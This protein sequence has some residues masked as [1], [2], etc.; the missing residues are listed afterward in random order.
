M[1]IPGAASPLFLA[2]AAAAAAPAGHQI[3]RS[4]RFNQSD[5]ANLSKTFSSG[6]RKTWTLSWWM[7]L[8]KLGSNRGLFG[9][10]GSSSGSPQFFTRINT[11]D[12]LYV[13]EY[14]TSGGYQFIKETDMRLRD[15][16]AWYH[17]V[18]QFD[19]TQS[20]AEDGFKIYI[21]G[22]RVT[23]WATNNLTNYAQNY[24]GAWNSNANTG[25]HKIGLCDQYFDGYLAEIHFV[26]GTQLAATD[27]G[28]ED[29]NGVW[30]PIDCKDNLTYGTNGFYL[31]F[32]D[33]SSKDALGT[34]SSGRN[35]TWTVTNLT[36]G[37]VKIY[38]S[39]ISIPEGGGFLSGRPP[40]NA[41]DGSISTI[42]MGANTST[43]VRWTYNASFGL[44]GAVEI[45]PVGA[46][47]T[48][49][50]DDGR[51]SVTAAADQYTQISSAV[52][53]TWF[54]VYQGGGLRGNLAAI[55]VGGVVLVDIAEEVDSLIDTP[56]NYTAASGNN[57]GNYCTLNPLESALTGLNNGNLN[58]GSS[59][60]AGWKI[61]TSTM[62][63]SSGK[64]YWEGFT[65]TTAT[66][67]QGW[68]WGFCNVTPSSLTD[69]YGTG[70]WSYQH[71]VVYSQS[72]SGSNVSV[73]AGANDLLAYA[74]DMDAGTCK[75]YVNNSLI[76]TFT[77]ITGTITPFVGSYNSPT[78]TV[79]FGQRPFA[80]TPPTGHVSLCTQ[81]LS[82]SAYASIADG[83]T[84][85]D[86]TT[87]NNSSQTS[88]SF[89]TT[90][91]PDLIITKRRDAT[92]N[93]TLQDIVRGYGD[94]KN[95]HPNLNVAETSTAN[96][97]S[98][99]DK[100]VSYGANS[101]FFNTQVVWYWDAGTSTASNTDGNVTA[102]VRANAAAGFSIISVPSIDSTN[103]I[104][105][106]GHQLNDAPY[107][108][109]SKNRDFADHWFCYHKDVQ[110]NNRQQL[111]L[112]T[113]DGTVTSGSDIWAHTSSV[114]G[115][116]GALYVA[117]GN[118]DDLI[119]FCWTPIE[120]YS[121]FG[122]YT[123]NGS[124]DGPFV[125]TGFRPK[126]V[127]RKRTDAAGGGWYLIDTE[128]DTYNE[129][130]A[131]LDAAD[132]DAEASG[133]NI[134]ILSNGFKLRNSAAGTNASGGTYVY[135][136]FAE[137]PFRT[138]RAR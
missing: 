3:D 96:I 86:I 134:D 80:H 17:C 2:T 31:K 48:V 60:S 91:T 138:A 39:G 106:V 117:S 47:M 28:E 102:N 82:E 8:G 9:M 64:Y 74:L 43:S 66:S 45:Y 12:R 84:A 123:G 24:D 93:W 16:S 94:N 44:S 121:A 6:N 126:F 92:S 98:V 14:N 122:S 107:F 115:F 15:P 118:T 135:A 137:H 10:P 22:T 113:T 42:T 130:D 78:V 36:A 54:N 1:S 105:T 104:R 52:D 62:A 38:S 20:T 99:S 50:F 25:V 61:C 21:N 29:S 75:L 101:N 27:F 18:F 103:T 5:S 41:F 69:P 79:N 71:N 125:Y 128:R 68:Q 97:T 19:S 49:T 59:G 32:A 81:N 116:N 46:A 55:K 51:T 33:N 131:F 133:T 72:S 136:A 108:I 111:R 95:L 112:N 120:G 7:K 58:S 110:T 53:F 73:T 109:I 132:S 37:P 34:D 88:G 83:S 13:Y 119:F 11:D 100:T 90:I 67:S 85:F 63:I 40:S 76:H 23:T 77:G 30:Q 87:F 57:G 129:A 4:L 56:T 127:I 35:N 124:T 89:T 26:D 65:D 70:K 114:M